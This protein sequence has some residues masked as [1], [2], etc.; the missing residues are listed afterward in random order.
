ML[1]ADVLFELDFDRGR[2]NR[3][4]SSNIVGAVH[5]DEGCAR[6][7]T[8]TSLDGLEQTTDLDVGWRHLDL[9]QLVVFLGGAIRLSVGVLVE[10]RGDLL[11]ETV[12]DVAELLVIAVD[13]V[14]VVAVDAVVGVGL[15]V[16]DSPGLF[17]IHRT[18]DGRDGVAHEAD[19]ALLP[20]A[21]RHLGSDD[22]RHLGVLVLKPG[23]HLGRL[24]VSVK[25]SSLCGC[26]RFGCMV[27]MGEGDI[28][29]GRFG[30][31]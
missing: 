30:A 5:G 3:H 4:A 23:R 11:G 6:A 22:G 21:G 19:V 1:V 7:M 17:D 29:L 27:D 18:R 2:A 28:Y 9:D 8:E 15:E 14:G 10:E 20:R 16:V 13:L 12:A 25:S 31:G 26:S 24:Y